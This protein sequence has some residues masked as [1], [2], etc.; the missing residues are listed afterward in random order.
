MRRDLNLLP[1]LFVLA[2]ARCAT[3]H[4]GPLQRIHVDSDPAGATVKTKDCGPGST[5]VA[6]TEAA[7]WVS[8][9]ATRCTLTVS[10][11][12]FEPE[13]ISLHRE[14]SPRTHDNA[15]A[16]GEM[17]D[18]DALDCNSFSDVLVAVFLGGIIS[19]TGF[20]V[21]AATGAMFE[22]QP[23]AVHVELVPSSQ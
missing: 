8:R 10:A 11:A 12:G 14:I 15:R 22:Q 7:V 2:F 9:R 18:G 3:V 6:T 16:I 17:C 5:R 4:H 21:D 19:G 13:T 1:I 23:N 20:G